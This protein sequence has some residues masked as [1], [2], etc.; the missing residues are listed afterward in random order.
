MNT[1][2]RFL[3]PNRDTTLIVPGTASRVITVGAYDSRTMSYA[4]F[5]G[6]GYT[7]VTNQM[8]P[9]LVAPGVAIM[10]TRAVL[11]IG[12]RHVFC[13]AICD[14]SGGNAD[15]MGDCERE[16]PVSVWREGEGVSTAWSTEAAFDQ[17]PNNQVG[18]GRCVCGIV[19]RCKKESGRGLLCVGLLN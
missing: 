14:R 17:W 1:G 15:G 3:R 18:M 7:R 4:E 12:N 10:T 19:C 8:K 9:D 13:H 6:R 2:T 5:F 11:Y 16:C